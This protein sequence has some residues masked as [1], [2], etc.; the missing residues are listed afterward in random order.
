MENEEFVTDVK[1]TNDMFKA[2]RLKSLDLLK[3]NLH[4]MMDKI[5]N[6]DKI[7]LFLLGLYNRFKLLFTKM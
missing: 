1:Y 5:N 6:Q 2:Y 7:S 4:G 3:I